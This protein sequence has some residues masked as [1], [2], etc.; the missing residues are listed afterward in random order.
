MTDFDIFR[1]TPICP[2]PSGSG[3]LGCGLVVVGPVLTGLALT[4][5]LLVCKLHVCERAESDPG[6]ASVLIELVLY[7]LRE[8]KDIFWEYLRI[9]LENFRA[10]F[11]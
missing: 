7:I 3:D 5:P 11:G 9:F 8:L 6:K 1:K 10:F 2:W 4:G